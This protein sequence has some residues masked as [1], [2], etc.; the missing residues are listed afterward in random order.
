MAIGSTMLLLAF[1]LQKAVADPGFPVGGA[2]TRWGSRPPT[3]AL[4]GGNV[5]ENE[6]FG[7]Q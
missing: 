3:R 6:R 1:C 5:C 2:W 4:F 7:P